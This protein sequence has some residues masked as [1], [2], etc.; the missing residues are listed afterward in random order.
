MA[1]KHRHNTRAKKLCRCIKTVRSENESRAI[2][3]CVHSVL[4][5]RGRTL[6][7]FS[8]RGKKTPFGNTAIFTI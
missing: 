2:A 4:K 6:K 3:I 1:V 7:R 5:R 8:C